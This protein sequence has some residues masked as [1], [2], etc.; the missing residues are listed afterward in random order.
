MFTMQTVWIMLAV[1]LMLAWLTLLVIGPRKAE[2]PNALAVLRY[3]PHLRSLA[4]IF[5][6]IP[7]LIMLYA[8][9]SF[10]WRTPAMMNIAGMLL[11]AGSLVAGLLLIEVTR[12]Q[13]ILTEEGITRDSPWSKVLTVKWGE[14]ERVRYSSLNQWFLVVGAGC[15]IRVSRHLSGIDMF[16]VMVR[17]KV[18]PERWVSASRAIY[19]V[20]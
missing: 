6:L 20:K 13:V 2:T 19:G 10:F 14:V 8:V 17:R 18:M 16:A 15:T 12:V 3:G 9:W 1:G 7:P 11:L 4:L 5:A